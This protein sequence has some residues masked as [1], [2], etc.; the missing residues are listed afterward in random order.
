M[1]RHL[2]KL[3]YSNWSALSTFFQEAVGSFF[4]FSNN[5]FFISDF[6]SNVTL[7]IK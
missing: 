4:F 7:V 6:C 5:I 2:L 3:L 1:F